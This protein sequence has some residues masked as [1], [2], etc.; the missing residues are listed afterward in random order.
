MLVSRD[1]DCTNTLYIQFSFKFI[2]KGPAKLKHHVCINILSPSGCNFIFGLVCSSS[3]SS[4]SPFPS[5]FHH[6]ACRSAPT[7]CCCSIQ[8]TE[9]SAG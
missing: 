6:Q 3:S 7:R 4:S 8:S 1:L 9:A 5:S 2:T